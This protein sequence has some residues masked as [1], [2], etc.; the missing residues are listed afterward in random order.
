MCARD[1]TSSTKVP[2][3]NS[4]SDYEKKGLIRGQARETSLVPIIKSDWYRRLG[5]IDIAS[6]YSNQKSS[7]AF[8]Q[9]PKV[10][11]SCQRYSAGT[12][13]A[14]YNGMDPSHILFA[15]RC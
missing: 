3:L 10:P 11:G 4:R 8:V 6:P 14:N 9:S 13:G 2:A 5:D 1:S 15:L 12:R 7:R